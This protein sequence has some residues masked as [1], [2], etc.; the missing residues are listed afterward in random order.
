MGYEHSLA[1]SLMACRLVASKGSPESPS[2]SRRLI[3]PR[4]AAMFVTDWSA[5][6]VVEVGVQGVELTGMGVSMVESRWGS[7]GFW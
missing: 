2:K 5:V 3:S 6:V 7:L 4:E 1:M